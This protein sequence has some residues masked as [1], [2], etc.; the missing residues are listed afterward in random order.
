MLGFGGRAV[1]FGTCPEGAQVQMNPYDL[2]RHEKE[3]VGSFIANYTFN[4]A[5]ESMYRKQVRSDILFTYQLRVKEIN[6]A[7]DVHRAGQ[8]IKVLITP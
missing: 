1:M 4:P 8:S 2:M 5:I 6:K 7:I 3:I